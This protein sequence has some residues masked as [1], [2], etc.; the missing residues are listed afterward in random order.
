LIS[1]QDVCGGGG[2]DSAIYERFENKGQPSG[3]AALDGTARLPAAQLPLA[4]IEYKGTWNASSNTPTLSNGAG[5]L[6]DIYRVTTAGNSLG[7]PVAVGDVIFY[8]GSA[9]FKLGGGADSSVYQL[10]SEKAVA[11]GYASLD[12]GGKVPASQLPSSLMAYLGVWDAAANNPALANGTGSPGDVYRV[13]TA[14]TQFGITFDVGDYAIYNGTVWEK[15][16]TTD[17]VASVNGKTGIVTLTKADVGLGSVDNTADAAKNVLS[18]TKLTPGRTLNG[19]PFDGTANITVPVDPATDALYE[20]VANRGVADGYA[21]LGADG[22]VPAAQLPPDGVSADAGNTSVL[23]TDGLVFTPSVLDENGQLPESAL[24]D[25]VEFVDN[26]G[27]PDGY[28]PLD[29][30]GTIDPMYLDP[31]VP[32]AAPATGVAA[33]DTAVLSA[34]LA[35][36]S[37]AR[38]D[39]GVYEVAG[40]GLTVPAG[41]RLMVGQGA[42]IRLADGQIGGTTGVKSVVILGDGASFIGDID[43]NRDGQDKAAYNPAVGTANQPAIRGLLAAGTSAAPL[44]G[45]YVDATISNCADFPS[46]MTYVN[47]SYVRVRGQSNGGTVHFANCHNLEVDIEVDGTD[48]D[49]WHVWQ[50]AVDFTNCSRIRGRVVIKNQSGVGDPTTLTGRSTWNSGLTILDSTDMTFSEVD[51]EFTTVPA[52][53]KSLGISMLGVRDVHIDRVRI[54]GHTDVLWELGGVVNGT[55]G[56]LEL[57]GR[58][59]TS[60][61]GG[62]SMGMSVYN[63]A[64]LGDLTGR[65]LEHCRNLHFGGGTIRRLLGSGINMKASTD[66]TWDSVLIT[67]CLNGLWTTGVDQDPTAG[68]APTAGG[69]IPTRNRFLNCDFTFHERSGVLA[70]DLVD[71]LFE[72]CRALNNGQA[73]TF[74]TTRTGLVADPGSAGFRTKTSTSKTGLAWLGDSRADD[75]QGGSA[76]GFPDPNRPN[77]VAVDRP[78]RYGIGQTLTLVGAGADGADLKTRVNDVTHDEL[79]LQHPVA[80]FPEVVLTGTIAVTGKTITGTG[81]AFLTELV[82]RAWIKVG[83]DFRRVAK[84]ASDTSATLA[85]AFPANV[86]AGTALTV[87]RVAINTARSQPYGYNFSTDTVAPVVSSSRTP[88]GNVTGAVLDTSS[89]GRRTAFAPRIA[90]TLTVLADTGQGGVM[91]SDG[92]DASH[93]LTLASKGN[94]TITLRGDGGNRTVFTAV[95]VTN[96]VNSVT[97]TAAATGGTPS[98]SVGGTDPNIGLYFNPKGTGNI[99]VY[100]P[101]GQPARFLAGGPDAAHNWNILTKSTG[102]VQVSTGTGSIAQVEVKGH[103]HTVAQVAGALSWTTVPANATAPGTAGQLAYDAGFIYVCVAANVWVRSPLTTW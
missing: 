89:G 46:H 22:K 58:Y 82:G 30:T 98:L 61:N 55:F 95:P 64:Q 93:G 99:G 5:N 83:S 47:D 35:A 79:T 102:V 52:Q 2:G 54:V 51:C 67:G 18:A 88:A 96:A 103:T 72:N 44:T 21:S 25:G 73:A 6:G 29:S 66:N 28:V 40:T 45:L 78:E 32:K 92:P 41:K 9:W 1:A 31:F 86:P 24:P 60:R 17:A 12:S 90:S 87:V 77:V 43:G 94:G 39:D 38:A 81:T 62:S 20:K 70:E 34:A 57:D 80:S 16:D 7:F 50:H 63:A 100:A 59:A 33:D 11:G 13:G 97:V 76:P 84:V 42:A 23:G 53:T 101:T 69:A 74:G 19:V 10:K 37:F 49:G 8:D 15:S 48:N 65:T 27:Q 68:P 75:T 91:S 14:G 71:T 26:K 4:A 56:G 85:V 36:E 3:Y